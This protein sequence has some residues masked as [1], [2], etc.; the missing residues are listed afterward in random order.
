MVVEDKGILKPIV[1]LMLNHI[2]SHPL[3]DSF[4][5]ILERTLKGTLDG[6]P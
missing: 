4:M 6:N 1:K 3:K 2:L 5:G